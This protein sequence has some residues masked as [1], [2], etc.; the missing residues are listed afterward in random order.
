MNHIMQ[1][2][3]MGVNESATVKYSCYTNESILVKY[4]HMQKMNQI[5]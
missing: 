3:S 4:F 2:N 5:F 1:Y